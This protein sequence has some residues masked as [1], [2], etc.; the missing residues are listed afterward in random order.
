MGLFNIPGTHMPEHHVKAEAVSGH[1]LDVSGGE[2][3][4]KGKKKKKKKGVPRHALPQHS[5]RYDACSW[6]PD[7]SACISTLIPWG[8]LLGVTV[9]SSCSKKNVDWDPVHSWQ[10]PERHAI[11]NICFA[12]LDH[13][14]F[15]QWFLFVGV[16]FCLGFFWWGEG[17]RVQ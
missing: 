1:Q 5:W 8:I 7:V 14:L 12:K 13:I 17:G 10:H 9:K 16:V 11:A 4:K 6:C 3:K 15:V 2:G